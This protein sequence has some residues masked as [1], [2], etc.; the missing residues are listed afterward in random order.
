L[1]GGAVAL[2]AERAAR[3]GA[4]RDLE[5]DRSGQGRYPNRRAEGGLGKG[6]REVEGE[7]GAPPS[8][9]RVGTDV[10]DDEQ[11]AGRAAVGA[12]P[13]PSLHPD[14]LVVSD[15][16]RNADLDLAGPVHDARPAA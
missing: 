9:Q 7:V 5:G 14:A 11:V 13:A 8:E 6:D 2:D 12:D 10:D 4:R 15:A 3:P 16:R 1:R